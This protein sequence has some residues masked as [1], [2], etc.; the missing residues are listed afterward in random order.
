MATFRDAPMTLKLLT[1][2]GIFLLK[3]FLVNKCFFACCDMWSHTVVL[4]FFQKSHD[5]SHTPR[6]LNRK[7]CQQI[8]LTLLRFHLRIG[9]SFS[10]KQ[11]WRRKFLLLSFFGLCMHIEFRIN[12]IFD[13]IFHLK[14]KSAQYLYF[15]NPFS[16]NADKV[17]LLNKRNM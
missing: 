9:I 17:F 12:F 6:S 7:N 11:N 13:I 5:R 15:T 1:K 16:W 2:L 3:T 4:K 8:A 14:S 10:M